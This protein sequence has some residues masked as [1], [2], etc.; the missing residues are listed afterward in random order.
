MRYGQ[1]DVVHDKV[2]GIVSFGIAYDNVLGV[3]NAFLIH[4]CV[5]V[6]ANCPD[7]LHRQLCRELP[8]GSGTRGRSRQRTLYVVGT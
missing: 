2:L 7:Q 8:S 4:Y 3:V 1:F 5:N 6:V